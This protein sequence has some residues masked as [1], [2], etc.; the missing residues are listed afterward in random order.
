MKALVIDD[1]RV[2]RMIAGGMLKGMGYEV[3]E[4]A[5][6][7]DGLAVLEGPETFDLVLVDW[8]MPV[9]SGIEFVAAARADARW[10]DLPIMMV[11]SE[12][13]L[14]FM[15]EAI[16]AGATEYIMKPFTEEVLVDKLH[17]VGLPV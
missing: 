10:V 4:A 8:N 2:A 13:D 14:S 6:G 5:N 15:I 9:M 11:T 12:A 7:A 17:I 3:H 1:S 16:E